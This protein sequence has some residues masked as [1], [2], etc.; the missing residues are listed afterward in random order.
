MADLIGIDC[1]LDCTGEI[2][3]IKRA[4]L[5]FVGRYYRWPKSRFK[6]L[7][8]NEAVALSGAGLFIVALWEWISNTISNF[9]YHHGYDQGT[10][11]YHQGMLAHQPSG[12]PIYFAV[13]H[14]FS[15]AQIA[16]P[17]GDYFKGIADAFV[18][19]GAGKSSY[20]V[21]VYGSGRSCDWLINRSLAKRSWLAESTK[22]SGTSAY[23]SWDIKQSLS[24]APIG[25]LSSGDKGDFDSDSARE[26]Y[27]GFQVSS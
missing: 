26:S 25:G 2:D 3:A 27:G 24:K 5:V 4:S 14:D 6:P 15:A 19:M 16:G 21:G 13:D 7:T 17:V 12:T 20:D 11:A 22:W 18:A 23:T 10:S 8:H 1:K 9:S